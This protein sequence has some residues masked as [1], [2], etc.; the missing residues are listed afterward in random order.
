MIQGKRENG[1]VC[2]V[3]KF[4]NLLGR[5]FR[6]KKEN[7]DNKEGMKIERVS[8][9][10]LDQVP[11]R[12]TFLVLVV[13]KVVRGVNKQF[14]SVIKDNPSQPVFQNE[15]NTYLL[16]LRKVIVKDNV[17]GERGIALK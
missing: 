3:K 2:G 1:N 6:Q 4:K 9:V 17:N 8:T 16:G 5:Q 14:H 11:T 15:L 7:I 10:N 12:T 13:C